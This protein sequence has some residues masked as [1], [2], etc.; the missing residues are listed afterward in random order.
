MWPMGARTEVDGAEVDTSQ[1]WC[2]GAVGDPARMIRLGN[3]PE[4]MLCVRCGRWAANQARE[5]EDRTATGL[6]VL[7]R[8]KLRTLRRGVVRRGWQH[9]RVLGG[10]LRW[11]GRRLP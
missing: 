7:A 2:C 8:D 1:C 4:V 5:I 10:P 3:H 6:L 9:N 11:I